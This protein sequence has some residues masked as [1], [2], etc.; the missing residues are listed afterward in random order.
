VRV[1]LV[2]VVN[3]SDVRFVVKEPPVEATTV[4]LNIA[5]SAL[6]GGKKTVVV[7]VNNVEACSFE[8]V[9]D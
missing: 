3:G 1:E 6:T 9:F 5:L 7:Y 8:V 2:D 4:H